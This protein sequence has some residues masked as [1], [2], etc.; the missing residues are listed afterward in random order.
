M[1]LDTDLFDNLAEWVTMGDVHATVNWYETPSQD[2]R[3]TIR[4]DWRY[5]SKIVGY[6]NIIIEPIFGTDEFRLLWE[7]L[8]WVED[9]Q[10]K[11]LY[12]ELVQTMFA[13][14]PRY[15]IVEIVAAPADPQAER[16]LASRGFEWC[17]YKFALDLRAP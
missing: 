7:D 14:M 1:L 11:G 2:E 17:D 3:Y 10:G 9:W 13:H 8:R 6:A 4:I 5:Q 16:I 15:G 12:T